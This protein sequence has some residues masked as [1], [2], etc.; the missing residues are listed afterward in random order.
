MSLTPARNRRGEKDAMKIFAELTPSPRD[1]AL[2][3][4]AQAVVARLRPLKTPRSLCEIAIDAGDCAW[5]NEWANSLR[6]SATVRWM[7]GI[8]SRNVALQADGINLTYAESFGCLFL[9]LASETARRES[10]EGRVWADIRKPYP[11]HVESALFLQGQPRDILKD[12][13]ESAARKLR[14]RNVY[15]QA[16]TQEYYLTAYLQFGFTRRGFNS[17]LPE[18]LAG[19]GTPE[20]VQRLLGIGGDPLASQS[21]IDLWDVL[22]NYRKK[23]NITETSA[24]A[25]IA[26]SAWTLPEWTDDLLKQARAKKNL[27]TADIE[28]NSDI[29]E[30]PPPEFL[31]APKLRWSPPDAPEFVCEIE[32]LADF[33]L[34]SDRYLIQSGGATLARIYRA[35]DGSYRPEPAAITFSLDSPDRMA[36]LADD[37][38]DSPA[39]QAVAL[40]DPMEDVEA[41]DLR[42]GNRVKDAWEG[43]IANGRE[44]GLL[45]S[46]DLEVQPA[47]MAFHTVGGSKK[48]YLYRAD[49]GGA[50]AFLQ[51]EELWSSIRSEPKPPLPEPDW[52]KSVSVQVEP[53]NRINLSES[54]VRKLRIYGLGLETRLGYVRIGPAPLDFRED[55]Y[56]EYA[57]SEFDVLPFCLRG[58]SPFELEVR[59]GLRND[60]DQTHLKRTMFL[61]AEGAL[62]LSEDG[63]QV[64]YPDDPMSAS[65]AKRYAYR[66]FPPQSHRRDLALM[67]GPLFLRRLWTRPRPLDSIGGYG[68]K[69]GVRAPYNWDWDGYLV[70]LS[71]ETRDP[72]VITSL[73]GLGGDLLLSLSQPI[74][75]GAAHSVII[76][77]P[78]DSP[79]ILNARESV[80]PLDGQRIWRISAPTRTY[81][82]TSFIAIAYNGARIGAKYP[83]YPHLPLI[84]SDAEASEIAAMIRWMRAPILSKDWVRRVREFANRCPVPVL[85]AWVGKRGLPDCLSHAEASEQWRP[86]VRRIFSEWNPNP[87]EA[88]SAISEIGHAAELNREDVIIRAFENLMPFD[89]VLL[90]RVAFTAA[91]DDPEVRE[92]IRKMRPRLAEL[93][94]DATN[95]DI[96]RRLAELLE[97]ASYQ[98]RV[99]MRFLREIARNAIQGRRVADLRPVDRNN[100]DTALSLAPVCDYLGLRILSGI[101]L[102]IP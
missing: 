80:A 58:A 47:D 89:P 20:S 81:N 10:S 21:F 17:R 23:N 3:A 39:N 38:G 13:M 40:W 68:D 82:E 90:G 102:I 57:T 91:L 37:L 94:P 46:A 83:D 59:L 61:T 34:T 19:Q 88:A 60:F 78:G 30:P 11:R 52:A 22:R 24:R 74:E 84:A 100:V 50:K 92:A 55:G 76:W 72:G 12:A 45:L 35:E 51:G 6:P 73:L 43:K 85:G 96:D 65:D 29:E 48:L 99:D 2:I 14:L 95:D 16:G 53:N 63:W 33:D 42:D 67:E 8:K 77:T 5:L 28:R 44:Y 71:N 49:S 32:N 18:W 54:T 87:Q 26:A 75:P 1:D 4:A 98:T 56:G 62:R 36:S 7:D 66:I 27:G 101:A 31:G 93:P 86:V 69:L 25:R 79:E 64:V 41:F 9:L 70:T 97:L 15:G